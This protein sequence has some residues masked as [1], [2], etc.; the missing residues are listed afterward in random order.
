MQTSKITRLIDCEKVMLLLSHSVVSYSSVT[1]WTVACQAPLFTGFSRQ[2]YQ[3]GLPFPSPGIFLTQGWNPGLL[4]WQADSFITE[5]PGEAQHAYYILEKWKS[6]K[7]II[8]VPSSRTLSSKTNP[9][10]A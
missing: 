1:P 3:S 8:Q 9:M 7:S 6:F 2:E 4:H 5:P 10:Q